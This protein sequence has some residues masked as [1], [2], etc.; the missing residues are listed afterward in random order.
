MIR[1]TL[2]LALGVFAC[3]DGARA[4]A[5]AGDA[6]PQDARPSQD[7]SP[8]AFVEPGLILHYAFEDSTTVVRDS[9]SRGMDGTLN[10]A[11][12]WTAAGRTGRGIA[13]SGGTPA[14]RYVSLPSGVLTGVDNFTIATWVKLNTISPWVRIYD[15]GNGQADAANRFMYLTINGFTGTVNDGIHA[16]SFGGSPTNENILGSST[17]LPTGVWKHVTLTGSGG[18]RTLYIDGFPAGRVTGGPVVAP[19]EMEPI[20]PSSWI[21]KS[22]FPDPG[23]DGTLDD[24]RIYDRVLAPAQIADLAW[25]AHDYSYWRF[26]ETTGMTATDSSDNAIATVLANGPTWSTGRLGGAIDFAGG[27]SGATGPQVVFASSPLASCTT[28]LTVA[29]WIKLHALTSWS[30]IFD[31]GT[32]TTAF[33]YLAPTD[34]AGMHFAMVSPHGVFDM[35]TASP[36]V[37]ADDTWHHVAVTVDPA[38][39]VTLYVDGGA[40]LSQANATD[41]TPADFAATTENWLGRSRFPDPYLDGAIDDLRISCRAYSAD[42]IVNLSRP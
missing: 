16:S 14:A 37:A 24:F 7:A 35:V 34:G 20:S 26:D 40:V 41:V 12:G 3:G 22:R 36:P 31:F 28:Q 32:S 21:G 38:K 10:D 2:V 15:I 13:M 39:L 6:A 33:I 30:R 25:P 8:D 4:L 11:A 5:G 9:S 1:R 19:R 18:D 29:A 42:E 23:L 17:Q 27:A